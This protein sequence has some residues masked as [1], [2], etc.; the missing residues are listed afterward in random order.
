MHTDL[1][2]W[3]AVELAAGIRTRRISSRETVTS[4]LRRLD[5]VNPS[6]NAVVD[7]M[8]KEALAAADHAD[9]AVSAGEPLG[10]LHGVP[11]TIKINVDCEGRPT[12]NGVVAFRDRIAMVD[13]PPVANWRK[14]GAIVIGRTNVPAFCARFFTDNA[15]HG[16]TLNPW[17]PD[18]TPGGSS[19]GAAAALACGIGP[20]AHGNDRAGSIRQPA[21]A[22]GV[23]GI[24]PSLGRVPGLQQSERE[25]T[26]ISQLCNMQGPLARNIADLRLGLE[27]MAGRDPHDPWWCPVPFDLGECPPARVALFDD[28]PGVEIDPAVRGALRKAASG[29]EACGYRVEEAAPPRFTEAARLFFTLVKTEERSGSSQLIDEFGDDALRRA[30]ASTMA[31]AESLSFEDYIAALARRTTILREWQIF[32]ERY[33]L[34]LMPVSWKLPAPVDLDQTGDAAVAEMIASF[35]PLLA[36]S[37][38]GLPGLAVPTGFAD[39]V[40]V[41]VQLVAGRFREDVCFAAGEIIEAQ[42]GPASIWPA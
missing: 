20:L 4:C 16:R 3:S 14:A 22:C 27:M 10:G 8:A 41:G 30:R 35:H 34:I 12:T 29:L 39:G 19:G 15:L 11:V 42:C 2:R 28:L 5:E 13:A 25:P 31:T 33:P 40:P 7:V 18:R 24:R 17:V 9:A 37:V 6:I 21:Y 23:T 32:M 1:W 38:L 26:L 36:I